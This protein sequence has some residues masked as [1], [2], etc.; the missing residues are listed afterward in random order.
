MATTYRVSNDITKVIELLQRNVLYARRREVTRKHGQKAGKRILTLFRTNSPVGKTE[1]DYYTGNPQSASTGLGRNVVSH[2]R[3][4]MR[5]FGTT[6]EQGWGEPDIQDVIGGVSVSIKNAAP[7]AAFLNKG[8]IGHTIPISSTRLVSFWWERRQRPVI[9]HEVHHPGIKTPL[10]WTSSRKR[11][12][13]IMNEE[14]RQAVA[15]LSAPIRRF[16]K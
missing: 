7:H 2:G 8:T 5:L 9:F 14:L 11:A 1:P 6:L 15:E 3:P 12:A 4:S 13:V 10:G 16:F